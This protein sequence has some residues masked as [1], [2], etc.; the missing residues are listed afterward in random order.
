M[1]RFSN[2]HPT[3]LKL[4]AFLA[5][6]AIGT[7]VVSGCSSRQPTANLEPSDTVSGTVAQQTT[8]PESPSLKNLQAAYNGESNAHVMY[9]AFAK[10]AN[11][12]GYKDVA[13]LFTAVARAEEIHRDNHAKVIQEM[14]ATPQN[15]ITTPEVKTTADNLD[16]AIGKGNLSKA[17][18]GETYERDTMYPNFI[19]E[20]KAEGNS[21][22]IQTF[23]YAL[24]A[25]TQY[26]KLY[27]EVKANLDNWRQASR[28]FYVCTVSGETFTSQP[29][30]DTC[31]KAESGKTVEQVS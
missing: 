8:Q 27:T 26:A 20:A 5:V 11:E 25:E 14:G 6:S 18:K 16:K 30:A 22:A 1:I 3:A 19:E 13:N 2:I 24:A 9:L 12:E 31:P 29:S 4:G 23:E 21:N 28:Q 7:F 15:K 10:K 17:I